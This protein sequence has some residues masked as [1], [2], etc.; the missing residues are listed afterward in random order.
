MSLTIGVF[1]QS[2]HFVICT[3]HPLSAFAK[4]TVLLHFEH[5]EA[6]VIPHFEQL[7]VFKFSIIISFKLSTSYMINNK[8]ENQLCLRLIIILKTNNKIY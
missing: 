1:E 2:S 7:A 6:S 8:T 4:S 5:V 3:K